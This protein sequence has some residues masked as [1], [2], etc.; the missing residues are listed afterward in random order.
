MSRENSRPDSQITE[1]A[2]EQI[3]QLKRILVTL[4]QKYE[5]TL[6]HLNQQLQT[7][8][9]QKR[10][11]Q[12]ELEQAKKEIQES[13]THHE[14][15][16]DALIQQQIMLKDLLQ[17]TQKDADEKIK[18]WQEGLFQKAQNESPDQPLPPAPAVLRRLEILEER[19]RQQNGMQE[20]YEQV[21]EDLGLATLQLEEAL[22]GRLQAEKNLQDLQELFNQ[23]CRQLEENQSRYAA[24]QFENEKSIENQ[25]GLKAQLEEEEAKYKTAQQHLAKKVKEAALLTEQVNG[26]QLHLIDQER[27][28]ESGKLH[29]NDLQN[30]LEISIK[31]EKRLQ[32]QL[33]EALKANENQA[34]KW[35]E[36]Y[37]RMYDKWQETETQLRDL[38]KL[39]EKHQQMQALLANIGN[40]MTP[41]SVAPAT[42]NLAIAAEVTHIS[43]DPRSQDD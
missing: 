32:E 18:A 35:E 33:H 21:K 7:E 11:F 5:Q 31:Q 3:I 41:P 6:Q 43:Q 13:K 42:E 28:L 27:M 40:F 12:T 29:I 37:F 36:K 23:Q 1:S 24:L 39:E 20:K 16:Y 17:K 8:G 26:L 34:S 38:K 15:E 14:E 2:E 25:T 4:K 9:N 19:L 22:D 30:S 10:A